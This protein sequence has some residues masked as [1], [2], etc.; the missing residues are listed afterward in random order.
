MSVA[1]ATA[2]PAPTA[3]PLT[4][5]RDDGRKNNHIHSHCAP[6]VAWTRWTVNTIEIDNTAIRLNK[7]GKTGL[8]GMV[9]RAEGITREVFRKGKARGWLRG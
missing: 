3:V 7:K 6:N 4:A 5:V 1:N 8:T 2:R 9:G